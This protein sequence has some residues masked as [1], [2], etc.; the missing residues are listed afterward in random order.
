MNTIPSRNASMTLYSTESCIEGH[1]CRI[2]LY[3]KQVECEVEFVDLAANPAVLGELNPYGES[4]TLADRELV[5][6][7]AH[8]VAEYL[9]DRL[10]HPP[11]MPPDPVGRGRAR[12]LIYRFRREWLNEL[13]R[14]ELRGEKPKIALRTAIRQDLAAM[15]PL[16]AH[17]DYLLGEEFSL[18]DCF[19]MP[20]LWRL[21]HYKIEL[22]VQT[23]PVAAYMHRVLSRESFKRSLSVI[24]RDMR[25]IERDMH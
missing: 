14:L 12:M 11:L 13:R 5:L 25:T 15:S 10:P 2:V 21:E 16:L 17:Q 20:V 8:I 9:D 18:A 6:F 19:L 23:R 3:E 22:P 7:G 4:P 24:E 1:A